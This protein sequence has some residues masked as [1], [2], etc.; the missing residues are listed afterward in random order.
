MST[1]API[2][3]VRPVPERARRKGRVNVGKKE[4]WLST[5]GG[6]ALVAYGL[7]RRSVPALALAV[8]GGALI[9]HG[10]S[11]RDTLTRSLRPDAA[12]RFFAGRTAPRMSALGPTA[13]RIERSVTIARPREDLYAFWHDFANLPRFM[14][15]LDQVEVIDEKRSRWVA[16]APV[17]RSV[18]WTAEIVEDRENELIS[19]RSIEPADIDNTGE[20]RFIPAPGDRGTE[21]HV[22]LEYKPPTGALGR[23]VART[24]GE[25]PDQQL[26]HDLRRFKQIMEAG[27]IPTTD[28][29]PTGR[30][31]GW[32]E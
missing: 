10:V 2:P 8:A 3:E 13:T 15:H 12:R 18:A 19:W 5:L 1:T 16:K 27:E 9:K 31:A 20:V 7:A 4:R 22:A 6:G 30:S 11:G 32:R 17:G 21:V 23:A 25:E 14:D 28:G 29:Q 24:L 26:R